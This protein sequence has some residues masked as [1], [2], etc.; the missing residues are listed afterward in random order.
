MFGEIL[1]NFEASA[2]CASLPDAESNEKCLLPA[3]VIAGADISDSTFHIIY[4]YSIVQEI[5]ALQG[6]WLNCII[7]SSGPDEYKVLNN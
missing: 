4:N 3:G 2:W 1:S 6:Q 5:S 7:T